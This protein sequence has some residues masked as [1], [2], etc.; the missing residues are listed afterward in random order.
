MD[1]C[2]PLQHTNALR[3]KAL[4]QQFAFH[5]L[6]VWIVMTESV[7]PRTDV[8]YG[9]VASKTPWEH[10]SLMLSSFQWWKET[11]WSSKQKKGTRFCRNWALVVSMCHYMEIT[12]C[13]WEWFVPSFGT[14][15]IDPDL[16]VQ[17][18]Y[19]LFHSWL[20]KRNVG[21]SSAQRLWWP[22]PLV[23]SGGK[24]QVFL[25][26]ILEN[27]TIKPSVFNFNVQ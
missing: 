10:N 9:W 16:G 15:H 2:I 5:C 19:L 3:I 7:L 6:H 11:Q 8:W 13:L 26:Y 4:R 23:R 21:Q 27:R 20:L 14:L 18:W 1:H 25:E 17:Q 24:D 12:G 22:C